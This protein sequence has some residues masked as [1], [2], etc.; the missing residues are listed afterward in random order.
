MQLVENSDKEKND[1]PATEK[2]K[3]RITGFSNLFT[4]K[5][6]NILV[7]AHEKSQHKKLKHLLT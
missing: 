2:Q 1:K 4:T 3:T 5:N 7:M 6:K